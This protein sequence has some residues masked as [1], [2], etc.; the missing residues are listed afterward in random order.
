MRKFYAIKHIMAVV[1]LSLLSF[2]ALAGGANVTPLMHKELDGLTNKEGIMLIVEYAPGRYSNKH[3]H[4][5]HSFV[6]VLEGS[7]TMQVAGSDPVTL[8]AG[9]TYYESPNDIHLVSKNASNTQAAKFVVFV[10]KEIGS[11]VVIPVR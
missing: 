9:Q 1:S 7:V 11:P 4:D 5:A 2:S 6:Y 8:E 10:L 3:R